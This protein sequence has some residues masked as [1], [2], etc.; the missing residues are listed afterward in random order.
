MNLHQVGMNEVSDKDKKC[1]KFVHIEKKQYL[2]R[3]KVDL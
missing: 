1:K 3:L 2:C